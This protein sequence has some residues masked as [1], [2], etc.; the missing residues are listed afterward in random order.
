M[1][2]V[3][4]KLDDENIA[5]YISRIVLKIKYSFNISFFRNMQKLFLYIRYCFIQY[6]KK[7]TPQFSLN[8]EYF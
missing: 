7:K 5:K 6:K 4:H 3:C 8:V 1:Y 2:I